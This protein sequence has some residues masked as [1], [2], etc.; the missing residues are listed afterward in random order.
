MN[1]QFRIVRVASGHV[2]FVIGEFG[3]QRV[4][5]PERSAA[6]I[7]DDIRRRFPDATENAS[8]MPQFVIDLTR[9]FSG[10]AV[11]FTVP[12][13]WTGHSSFDADVWKACFELDYGQVTTYGELAR[14]IRRPGAARAVGAS[15]SRNPMPIVIPCHRVLRGDGSLGGYSGAEGVPFKKRLLQM[16]AAAAVHA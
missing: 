15:M 1:Q 8:L 9:Y 7:R 16:E 6:T 13:D 14:K 10:E 3:L 4:Y 11:K 2:G 5:L 12:I